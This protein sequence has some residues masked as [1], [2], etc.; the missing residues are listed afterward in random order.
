MVFGY[1]AAFTY[2]TLIEI[3]WIGIFVPLSAIFCIGVQFLLTGY[4]K[5]ISA[6]RLKFSDVRGKKVNEII[7]GIKMIKFNTWEKIMMS[8]MDTLREKE[9]AYLIK[10]FLLKGF[11]RGITN[12]MPLLAGLCC[13]WVYNNQNPN[14]PLTT[15]TTYSLI[16]LFNGFVDP[17]MYGLIV[18]D[19]VIK[20]FVSNKRIKKLLMV[21]CSEAHVASVDDESLK[22][23]EIVIE[24]GNFGWIDEKIKAVF[25]HFMEEKSPK[26]EGKANTEAKNE[27]EVVDIRL[28][29]NKLKIESGSFVGVIGQVGSGK[30]TLL[31]TLMD[32]MIKHQGEI[33]K[34]GRIAYISQEAFLTNDTVRNNI[35]FGHEWDQAWYE[36]TLKLCELEADLEILP[37]RDFTQIGERGIN[38]SGGQ[39]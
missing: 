29:I 3:G 23:G 36:K 4:V 35:T 24:N 7:S 33:K 6:D 8:Q 26:S 22:V 9:R 27:K 15:A 25:Y 32:E 20:A 31:L 18:L 38:L 39:K 11:V 1:I 2:L 19:F 13:F 17:I 16:A 30:T 28:K 34:N 5:K 21:D 12:F 14:D 10:I 37:G